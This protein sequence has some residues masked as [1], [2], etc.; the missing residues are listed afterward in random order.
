MRFCFCLLILFFTAFPIHGQTIVSGRI[1]S[2]FN[3]QP[4]TG[5]SVYLNN[6]TIGTTTDSAGRYSLGNVPNGVHELVVSFV[7]YQTMIYKLVA[8]GRSLSYTFM[9]EQKPEQM[10]SILILTNEQRKRK[11][12][13]FRQ[14]FL[15]NTTAAER[16]RIR[17]EDDIIFEATEKRGDL[18]A[19]SDKPLEIINPELGYR[20]FFDLE[21]LSLEQ[22]K[23][24]TFFYGYARYEDMDSKGSG[25]YK[26]RR[27]LYYTGSTMHFF[28]SLHG[29][30]SAS[31]GFSV[32]GVQETGN[33]GFMF[34]LEPAA[35]LKRDSA[36]GMQE[37]NADKK[38]IVRFNK[39][40]FVKNDLLSRTL[41]SGNLPKGIETTVN[42]V[43]KPVLLDAS[44]VLVNPLALSYSGFWSAEKLALM[45]PLNYRPGKS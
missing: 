29:G 44:G 32:F 43:E 16:C 45:L 22:D 36:S 17:N 24:H 15:G 38:F 2:A 6:T 19:Y 11:L 4:L 20:I 33:A 41:V 39:D 34:P 14:L 42:L 13:Q 26:R 40:P 25:R 30:Y 8:D 27:R 35:M 12:E 28:H 5:A 7:S 10:R 21:L 23:L 1:L 31:E 3:S 18:R 37:I 9:L